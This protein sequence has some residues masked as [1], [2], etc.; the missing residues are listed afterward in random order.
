MRKFFVLLGSIFALSIQAQTIDVTFSGEPGRVV[1]QKVFFLTEAQTKNFPEILESYNQASN[2]YIKDVMLHKEF[3]GKN[4]ETLSLDLI[5]GTEQIVLMGVSQAQPLSPVD[6]QN[7][8]G[9]IAAELSATSDNVNATILVNNLDTRD[10][11][12]A[13]HIAYGYHLRA[14]HFDKYK[15]DKDKVISRL[16]FVTNNT[17]ANTT[18]YNEDL[19]YVAQGVHMARD[20]AWEPGKTIYPASFVEEVKAA[21]KDLDN[22]DIE[23]LGVQQMER[24][25]MGALLGVGHGSIHDPKL[26][27]IEYKGGNTGSAPLVLAGKGITFD[28]GGTS[29]K[30]NSGMWAMKSDL[31]GAAAVAGTMYAL[32]SRG[33]RAN[34]IGVM[35]LAENM[36]GSKAIRPGDVLETMKGTT[37]EI[38]STDAEGR[39]ILA[40]A[41]Y[42]AQQQY[43]P[44]MLVNIATLT[45]SAARALSD[46]YAALVTRDFAFSTEIMAVGKSAGEHVWPLPLHPNHFD[47]LQSNIADIKNSGVGNPG[48]SIGAAVVGTFVDEELPW[49]HLDIAGVDWLDK[50]T[51]TAPKG[52]HGWGVR[53]M[54]QL[55]REYK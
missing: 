38:I 25:D 28:T 32:A 26:L 2:G 23:V 43:N 14:Y 8:G 29:I 20:M 34:V 16:T 4:G 41:V 55:V 11:T 37:I 31:S 10:R 15:S 27:I 33:E 9:K 54:D 13:A 40:D 18:K 19:R 35:P 21:F 53:F 42:Y 17:D 1:D 22:I 48:A 3:T 49:V 50:A 5:A 39:L 6:L 51:D 46:E 7:L 24:L 44:K 52:A 12:A 30:P 45:G 36:P 47:Q